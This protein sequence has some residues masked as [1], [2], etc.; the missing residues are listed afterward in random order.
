MTDPTPEPTFTAEELDNAAHTCDSEAQSLEDSRGL[1]A[2]YLRRQAKMLRF[3]ARLRRQ[4]TPVRMFPIQ[5]G[6]AIPWDV[7]APFD[8]ICQRNHGGQTLERMAER[9]GLGLS[10]AIDVLNG[11]D[12]GTFGYDGND[13]VSRAAAINTL[14]TRVQELARVQNLNVQ[15]QPTPDPEAR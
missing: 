12:Y 5:R 2:W 3:A 8:A 15:P 11:S 6:P 13:P 4:L 10:E 1:D 14:L 7:I 9:G